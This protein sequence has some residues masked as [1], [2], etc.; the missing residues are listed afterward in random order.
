MAETHA[1]TILTYFSV[2]GDVTIPLEPDPKSIFFLPF[3]IQ[4]GW[5]ARWEGNGFIHTSLASGAKHYSEI[6]NY[7]TWD[8]R[9]WQ[10]K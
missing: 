5:I 7:T 4:N 6:I 3:K 2:G 1:S 8:G 10:A 9:N